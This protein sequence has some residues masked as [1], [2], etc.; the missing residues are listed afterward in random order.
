M[1]RLTHTFVIGALATGCGAGGLDA[2]G[3]NPDAGVITSDAG[4][5]RLCFSSNEC[6]VGWTCSEFG[7]C[8]PPAPLTDG[9]APPPPPEAEQ[10]L[11]APVSSLRYVW[12]AMTDQDKL[13]KIDGTTLDVAAIPVGH[14]P[15]V[16]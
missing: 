9:G 14:H 12:V 16:V 11:G 13:A 6:P 10:S 3:F 8:L 4:T 15:Q 1:A 2:K 5:D 7:Q